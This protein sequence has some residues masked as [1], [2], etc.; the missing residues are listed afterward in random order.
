[1]LIGD[2]A[3]YRP[4]LNVEARLTWFTHEAVDGS[5]YFGNLFYM[6]CA[7][8]DPAFPL[9]EMP[10]SIRALRKLTSPLRRAVFVQV[11]EDPTPLNRFLNRLFYKLGF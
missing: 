2:A 8:M 7:N 6:A 9:R 4:W 1:T 11:G 10:A 5:Y 3:V